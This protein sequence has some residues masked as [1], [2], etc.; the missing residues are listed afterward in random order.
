AKIGRNFYLDYYPAEIPSQKVINKFYKSHFVKIHM[1][2]KIDFKVNDHFE[3]KRFDGEFLDKL[4]ADNK[5]NIRHEVVEESNVITA[6][7]DDLQ[8][9]I[10]QYSEN[11]KAF[12]N[13]INC[14]RVAYY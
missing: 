4:I 6:S 7:T 2:Y 5:I 14:G 3:M 8:K 13:S 9:F 1:I 11:P 10:I 12:V